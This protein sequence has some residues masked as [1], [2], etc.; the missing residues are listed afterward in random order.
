MA[1]ISSLL[2]V[3]FLTGLGSGKTFLVSYSSLASKQGS[4]DTKGKINLV[5]ESSVVLRLGGIHER[6]AKR[7]AQGA[8]TA[9]DGPSRSDRQ[10]AGSLL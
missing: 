5:G 10:R 1:R 2:K 4:M 8:V 3:Y 9:I 7:Q 6:S